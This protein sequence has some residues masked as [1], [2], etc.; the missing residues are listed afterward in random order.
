MSEEKTTRTDET[1]T[2][3]PATAGA[4]PQS[5]VTGGGQQPAGARSFSQDDVN[6]IA[7][8]RAQRASASTLRELGFEDLDQARAAIETLRT[9]Q[10]ERQTET[11][12]LQAEL[13]EAQQQAEQARQE[14]QEA[15]R[16]A[17]QTLIQAAVVAAASQQGVA[18]PEDAYRL[19]DLG[20]ITLG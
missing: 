12:R 17:R 13:D 5:H 4:A 18:H 1:T 9:F 15:A 19:V 16:R 8:E 6:R 7:A 14:S 20:A 2:A 3:P 11:E 10:Q